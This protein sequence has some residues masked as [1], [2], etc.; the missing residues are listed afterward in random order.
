MKKHALA[1]GAVVVMSVTSSWAQ[2]AQPASSN[3]FGRWLVYGTAGTTGVGLG[4]GTQLAEKWSLRL[5]MTR[6]NSTMNDTQE[7][8]SIEAKIKLQSGGIYADY[9]PFA[10]SFRLTG[11]LMF[12]SPSGWVTATP[13]VGTT[14]TI[15]D[16]SY[17][18]GAGD[19]ISGSVQYPSTMPYLGIGWGLAHGTN[20]GLRFGLDL[21]AGIGS[22]KSKLAA[23]EGIRTAAANAGKDIAADLAVE[24]KKLNDELNQ[25]SFLPVIKVSVGYSF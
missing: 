24:E 5:E 23:S 7:D 19:N 25:V 13:V 22:L 20:K 8:L 12:K 18:F 1:V 21:G 2:T 4:L 3:A 10:S 11:G 14:A 17:T 9:F 6:S 15:G 16:V